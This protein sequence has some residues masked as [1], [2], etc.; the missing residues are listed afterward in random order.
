[1]ERAHARYSLD[2]D[3]EYRQDS[4]LYY[5]TGVTQNETMLVLMPGNASRREILFIKDRNPAREHWTGRRLSNEEAA[6]RTGIATVPTAS[7]FEPFISALLARRGFGAI[8]DRQAGHFFEA[9]AAGRAR[10]AL[11]LE[12]TRGVSDLFRRRWCSPE[13]PRRFIGFQVT[14]ATPV[15]TDLRMVKTA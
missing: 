4:N 15:L 7:E 1:M 13:D 5:L 6:A 9:L 8:D 10:V 12:P 11:A 3:Y 2:I 14:D